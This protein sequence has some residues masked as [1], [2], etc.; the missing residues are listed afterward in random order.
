[1]SAKKELYLMVK[2]LVKEIPQIKHWDVWNNNIL[3]DGEVTPFPTPAVFYEFVSGSW[4]KSTKGSTLNQTAITPIQSGLCEIAIHVIIKKTRIKGKDEIR[5]Y[6]IENLVYKKLHF[7]KGNCI[8][9]AL[10]RVRDEAVPD[11]NVWRDMTVVYSATLLESGE[12][13]IDC[14]IEEVENVDF[15]TSVDLQIDR[16]METGKRGLTIN[17]S[18]K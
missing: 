8:E 2:G 11:H 10:Q 9:G 3:R 1:M 15:D 6:D 4:D 16:S 12:S 17:I 13:G 5:H 14:E 18:D 7:K